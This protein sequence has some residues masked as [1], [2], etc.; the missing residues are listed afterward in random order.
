MTLFS[1]LLN[2]PVRDLHISSAGFVFAG[3]ISTSDNLGV[4]F[5]FYKRGNLG[6]AIAPAIVIFL[7]AALQWRINNL[8]AVP[9]MFLTLGY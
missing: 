9:G 2:L 6:V 1:V 7:S 8:A 3:R 4:Q 5:L